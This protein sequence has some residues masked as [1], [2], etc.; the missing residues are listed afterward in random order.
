MY[1]ASKRTVSLKGTPCFSNS[2]G[3]VL[4]NDSKHET[5]RGLRSTC[6]LGLLLLDNSLYSVRKPKLNP[7]RGRGN[8]EEY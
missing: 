6:M 2:K 4:L 7:K 8:E 1:P 3:F 5:S